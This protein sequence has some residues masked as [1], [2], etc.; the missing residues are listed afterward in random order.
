[1]G[2]VPPLV[3]LAAMTTHAL[4]TQ[5]APPP[6]AP[7]PMAT[8]PLLQLGPLENPQFPVPGGRYTQIRSTPKNVV[9]LWNANGGEWGRPGLRLTDCLTPDC[10]RLGQPRTVAAVDPDPRFIRMELL[11][12]AD[13]LGAPVLTFGAVRSTELHL[14]RCHDAGCGRLR[15]SQ[16]LG[17]AHK[18][19]HPDLLIP[20]DASRLAY[21]AATFCSR[22]ACDLRLVACN[23]TTGAAAGVA[24]I[25]RSTPFAI[26]PATHL[27]TGG[28]ENPSLAELEDGSVVLAYWH[29]AERALKL[30]LNATDA[31]ARRSITVA[32]ASSADGSSPGAWCRVAAGDGRV[33]I[34]FFDL[35]RGEL[36]R[37]VCSGETGRCESALVDGD[38]SLG[39]VSDF[40]AGGFPELRLPP[41]QFR[42]RG[43]AAGPVYVY[44]SARATVSANGTVGELRA[45]FCRTPAC[46][47]ATGWT[48]RVLA[49]GAGG[50]GR[51]ASMAF[52]LQG[53][54]QAPAM[55]VSFL[56]LQGEDAPEGM[57]AQLA[58]FER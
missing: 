9:V 15:W 50:F 8:W 52:V 20:R 38:V 58:L 14:V 16:V 40:G 23:L 26:D 31:A 2:Y 10:R 22:T 55:M 19:R 56:D 48:R 17:S 43:F 4:L 33:L 32:S 45:V 51:D 18:V 41:A 37:A 28:L 6:P 54:L 3:V 36:R 1:M 13:G 21:V 11:T 7:G 44:F 12:A 46:G 34:F 24:R 39:D 53:P 49:R 29:V 27:P 35:P 5:L 25:D 30:V 47:G 42:Q 57:R